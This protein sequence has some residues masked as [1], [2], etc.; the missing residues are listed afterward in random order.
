VANVVVVGSLNMDIVAVAESLPRG[1]E[2]ILGTDFFKAA[3]GKGA[4]QAYAAALLGGSVAMIGRVGDDEHGRQLVAGLA[5]AGCDVSGVRSIDAVTGVA[6]ILVAATGENS[7]VVVPGANGRFVP[8]DLQ[9][10]EQAL[11]DAQFVLLQLEIPLPTVIAAARKAKH[12]GA[13]VILDPAPAPA[14]LPRELIEHVDILTPNES[15]AT[16]LT[17]AE[18]GAFSFEDARGIASRVLAAGI[19][20]AVLKLGARGCLVARG[21][22]RIFISAPRVD[23]IDTTA[24]GDVFNGA[25]ATAHSEGASLVEACR[26]AVRAAS[27]S[28]TRRGAQPSAPTRSELNAFAPS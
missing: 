23:A 6:V 5:A 11:R 28:V 18:T 13:T 26:F 21:E 9:A 12:C 25:L 7:I 15:E 22:E 1:G 20:T 19:K 14:G 24:A 2:T 3:G 8:T 16:R 4:N 17:S 10:D 27:L